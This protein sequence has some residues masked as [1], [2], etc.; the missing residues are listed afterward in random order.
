MAPTAAKHESWSSGRLFRAFWLCRMIVYADAKYF[1]LSIKKP[2]CKFKTG[3]AGSKWWLFLCWWQK[4]N[5]QCSEQ[6]NFS[7]LERDTATQTD[8]K[9]N[10]FPLLFYLFHL[11]FTFHFSPALL[12]YPFYF[13]ILPSFIHSILPSSLPPSF[14]LEQ[15]PLPVRPIYPFHIFISSLHSPLISD[16]QL[17]FITYRSYFFSTAQI[18][19]HILCSHTD[20]H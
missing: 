18:Y 3:Q 6:L 13:S 11:Y 12:S 10:C 19:P 2:A 8:Y 20:V 14:I 7:G 1:N 16:K 4:S 17:L 15:L 5:R 9:E